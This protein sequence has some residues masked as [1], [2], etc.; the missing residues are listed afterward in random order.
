MIDYNIDLTVDADYSY[1]LPG[2]KQYD[3]ESRTLKIRLLGKNG[4]DILQNSRLT[5]N[6]RALK[7]DGNVVY[8]PA[9][10]VEG[11][12]VY[13]LSRQVLTAVGTVMAD[14]EVKDGE[15]V[16]LSSQMIA[17]EVE[18]SALSAHD[19]ESTS[20]VSALGGIGAEA[21]TKARLIEKVSKSIEQAE[22][23]IKAKLSETSET[24]SGIQTAE[25]RRVSAEQSRVQAE[26]S[27]H[28][29][30]QARA[31]EESTRATS[32]RD[33]A[34]AEQRR[35]E[36]ERQR[37]STFNSQEQKQAEWTQNETNRKSA[38]TRRVHAEEIR[39]SAEQGR[40]SAE[41]TR[42]QA[43]AERQRKESERTTTFADWT[44]KHNEWTSA[45][46]TRTSNEQ[47]RV[48][49]ETRRARQA[50]ADHE[51]AER[52]TAQ[53]SAVLENI[54]RLESGSLVTDVANIQVN[55]APKAYV[56]QLISRVIGGASENLDTLKE[57]ADVL[58]TQG[59]SIQSILT[60][61][62]T[63]LPKEEATRLFS[64]LE[65]K[66]TNLINTKGDTSDLVGQISTKVSTST[67][68]EFKRTTEASLAG[69]ASA[70]DLSRIQQEVGQGLQA[71]LNSKVDKIDG[72]GLSTNDYTT[73]EKQKLA[74]LSAPINNLTSTSTTAPLSAAQG[75]ELKR[76]ID[77]KPNT[78][79]VDSL[80]STSTT[81]ALSANQG[82]ELATTMLQGVSQF[83]Q[84]TADK[85][86]TGFKGVRVVS[87]EADA[88][89]RNFQEYLSLILEG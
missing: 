47:G 62:A 9:Q 69:K 80:E 74:S 59:G 22:T 70:S 72:K 20:D 78:P 26:Q 54:K 5:C 71:T 55:Y 39:V 88:K 79:V 15:R 35:A 28:A 86:P 33:R 43:E 66:L 7:P 75:K 18:P 8:S 23:S 27:R 61:L 40:A 2:M 83:L 6:F 4:E 36:A 21:I 44:K 30:E 76:L 64:N 16:V 57:L 3:S 50:S 32:E 41:N 73:A 38:E 45:E 52:D 63:K 84:D 42:V 14:I 77:S 48:D 10:L 29:A 17:I 34:T 85:I 37:T 46:N 12:A 1:T 25:Q 19:L 11:K 49:A 56:D 68:D 24:L 51:R 87:N 58:T 67:F 60:Q 13:T 31:R 81:S 89:D 65:N 53:T 82:R